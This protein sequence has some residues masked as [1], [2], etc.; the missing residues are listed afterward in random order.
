[1]E[2]FYRDDLPISLKKARNPLTRNL[3][4]NSKE[5][6]KYKYFE[7]DHDRTNGDLPGGTGLCSAGD[8]DL[9]G[10]ARTFS[11]TVSVLRRGFFESLRADAVLTLFL[12]G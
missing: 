12:N 6:R 5:K 8:K 9:K 10:G 1:M 7:C 3:P 4:E 2:C 11:Q